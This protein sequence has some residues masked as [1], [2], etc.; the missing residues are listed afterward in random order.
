MANQLS[1]LVESRDSLRRLENIAF[2]GTIA[3]G[4]YDNALVRVAFSEGLTAWIPW[5]T[6]RAH[7]DSTWLAPEVGEQVLVISPSGDPA[8]GVVVGSIY[9]D[10]YPA[11]ETDEK[12]TSITFEDGTKLAYNKDGHQLSVSIPENGSIDITVTGSANITATES[13]TVSGPSVTIDSAEVTIT[14]NL[15]LSGSFVHPGVLVEI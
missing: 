15:T 12:T 8:Q 7:A 3:E 13:V 5:T 1:E 2:F 4:D 11:Q 6:G 14:G 10:A 9:Q